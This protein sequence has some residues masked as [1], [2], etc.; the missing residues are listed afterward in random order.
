MNDETKKILDFLIKEGYVDKDL[1]L[2]TLELK[3]SAEYCPN[4]KIEYEL[5][6]PLYDNEEK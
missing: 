5:M 6:K 2:K 3:L 1:P 4:I